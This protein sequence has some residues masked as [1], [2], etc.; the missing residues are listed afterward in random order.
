MQFNFEINYKQDEHEL[1]FHNSNNVIESLNLYLAC[2]NMLK[3][4]NANYLKLKTV[5]LNQSQV[6]LR[7]NVRTGHTHESV[8]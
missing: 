5:P 3:G 8:T 7:K 4:P 1:T 2:Y 6:L